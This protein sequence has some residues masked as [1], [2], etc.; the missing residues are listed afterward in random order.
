MRVFWEIWAAVRGAVDLPT[1]EMADE[2]GAK[3]TWAK[4]RAA[5]L[6]QLMSSKEQCL[7]GGSRRRPGSPR[8]AR[9]K[10]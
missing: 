4:T 10:P 8:A 9:K 1:Q 5:Y 7:L 2:I 3:M 6:E